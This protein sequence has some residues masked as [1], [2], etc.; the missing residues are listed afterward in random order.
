MNDRQGWTA[1]QQAEWQVQERARALELEGAAP[2][3]DAGVASYRAVI[4]AMRQAPRA[5]VPAD[6]APRT[7]R[8]VQ[9]LDRDEAFERWMLRVVGL[10]AIIGVGV[11]GL[12]SLQ[13]GV[14][15]S[16]DAMLSVAPAAAML[17]SP[18]L[19]IAILAAATA[20]LIDS[21]QRQYR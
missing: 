11:F 21:L 15:L 7:A 12:P 9:E 8:L 10:L 3:R 18:W 1:A 14:H 5:G 17:N 13:I 16:A 4:R 2:G 6:F 20:G 19:W